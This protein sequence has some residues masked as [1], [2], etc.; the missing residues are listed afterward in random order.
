MSK[1]MT[2]MAASLA[3]GL[4]VAGCGSKEAPEDETLAQTDTAAQSASAPAGESSADPREASYLDACEL[5]MSAPDTREWKT[6]WDPRGKLNLG[7]GPSF[8]H[9]TYWAK[10]EDRQ[11]LIESTHPPLEVV[12]GFGGANGE[13]EIS[14]T[15]AARGGLTEATVPYSPGTYPIVPRKTG[16]D[17]PKGFWAWPFLYGEAM[18]EA[19]SGTLTITRFDT[20]GVAGSFHV[21]GAEQLGAQRRL[22]L[23]GTFDMPCR[24]G[25]TEDKCTAGKAIVD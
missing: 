7:E 23:D 20:Q 4:L 16:A 22:V 8:V 18:F 12:C 17:A 3:V 19:T 1:R 10:D 14:L 25:L 13:L 6:S 24:G 15:L 11:M 2:A 5:K 9:S 21:E